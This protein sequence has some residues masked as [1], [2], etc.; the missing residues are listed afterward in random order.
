MTSNS[1]LLAGGTGL[2]LMILGFV[3]T[4]LWIVM[5]FVIMGI[6]GTL[7]EMLKLMKQAADREKIRDSQRRNDGRF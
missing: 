5:P 6:H 2:L 3:L 4:I 1:E 7:K